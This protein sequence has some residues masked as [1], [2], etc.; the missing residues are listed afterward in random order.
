MSTDIIIK[1]KN[2]AQKTILIFGVSSFVGSNLAEFLKHD[3]KVIGTYNKTPVFIPGVLTIPCDVLNKDEIQLVVFAFKPDITI[4]SV[5][6]SSVEDCSQRETIAEALNTNGLFNVTESCER[7]KSQVCYI[8]SSHVF[9]GLKK[10]YSEVDIPNALTDYGRTQ[11]SSEFYIQKN[12]LNY[13]VFRTCPLYGRSF[14]H[15]KNTWFEKL[16]YKIAQ[17]KKLVADNIVYTGFLDIYYL[18]MVMRLC[19]NEGYNNRLFQVSTTDIMTNFEFAKAYCETFNQTDLN[20]VKGRW[21]YPIS[22]FAHVDEVG[23]KLYFEMDNSNIESFLKIK[24][25]T[26]RDS[27]ELTFKRFKGVAKKE[28]KSSSSEGLKYI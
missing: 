5:G 27:L 24:M 11:A 9:D 26:I 20:I 3:Y 14:N 25:P 19:F 22:K 28:S 15:N 1:N 18:A 12:S 17:G 16:E 10:K 2:K 4:Y 23:E 8:S 6:L 21:P 13:I 7:N